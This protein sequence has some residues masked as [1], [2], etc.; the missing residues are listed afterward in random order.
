MAEQINPTTAQHNKALENVLDSLLADITTLRTAFNTAMTKLNAD[1][2]VG[3][4]NYAADTALVT[5]T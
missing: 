1:T 5:T 4:S 3:D 2:A